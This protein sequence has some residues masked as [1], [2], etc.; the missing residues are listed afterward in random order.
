MVWV[1]KTRFFIFYFLGPALPHNTG[2]KN[3]KIVVMCREWPELG[4]YSCSS[5][6]VTVH[7]FATSL[8]SFHLCKLLKMFGMC[9][10][11]VFLH[12]GYAFCQYQT[13]PNLFIFSLCFLVYIFS[14]FVELPVCVYTRT[15]NKTIAY[16]CILPPPCIPNTTV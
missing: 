3:T 4:R 8:R 13:L 1:I 10:I 12:F 15:V 5:F 11:D 7:L 14:G 16:V 2:V 9:F 6:N